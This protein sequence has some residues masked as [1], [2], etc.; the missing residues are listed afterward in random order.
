MSH[1][2]CLRR[3]SF[4]PPSTGDQLLSAA[5]RAVITIDRWPH[6]LPTEGEEEGEEQP[7]VEIGFELKGS[8]PVAGGS[9]AGVV[10]D[11]LREFN[12]PRHTKRRDDRGGEGGAA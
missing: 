12:M 1:D 6:H 8:L 5:T 2:D 9:A 10:R 4:L 7:E 11:L 3:F